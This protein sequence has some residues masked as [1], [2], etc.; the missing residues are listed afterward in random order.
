MLW[1]VVTIALAVLPFLPAPFNNVADKQIVWWRSAGGL[2]VQDANICSMVLTEQRDMAIIS[3]DKES[4]ES[5]A[6]TGAEPITDETPALVRIGS[7]VIGETNVTSHGIAILL[8][9]RNLD[10]LLRDASQISADIA[11][12]P[13]VIPIDRSKI[14]ALMSARDKCR[15]ALR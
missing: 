2:V 14:E 5:V 4:T 12:H 6:F 3:W 9:G 11:Q 1:T 15:A 7:T 10:G 8:T 13:F